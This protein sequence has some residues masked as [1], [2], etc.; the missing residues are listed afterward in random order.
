M[1]WDEHAC[2]IV[3]VGL[4]RIA[5]LPN[6]ASEQ[7]VELARAEFARLVAG[8]RIT[9]PDTTSVTDVSE[10]L[11]QASPAALER[12]VARLR[13]VETLLSGQTPTSGYSARTLRLYKQ[14]YLE[15]NACWGSGLVGLLD[16]NAK[17]GNRTPRLNAESAALLTHF[18]TQSYETLKQKSVLRVYG[19]YALACTEQGLPAASY[20]TF[21][22]K[23]HERPGGTQIRERQGPRAAYQAGPTNWRLSY[24]TP[25][26]GDFPWQYGHI[27]HTQL[28]LEMVCART[29]RVLGRPWLTVLLDAFSRRI[30][31]VYLTFDPPSYRSCM[32]VLVECVRRH[33][34][35][36]EQIMVDNG[37]DFRSIYFETLLAQHHVTK[38]ARPAAEPRVGCLI[39]RLFRT[40]ETEFVHTLQGN[41]QIMKLVRQ[42]TQTV[43]PKTQAVWTLESF[44]DYF[45]AWSYDVYDRMS[46]STLGQSP[47]AAYLAGLTANG[48]RP[49]RRVIYDEAFRLLM[50]PTTRSGAAKVQPGR[51]VKVNYLHYW[52]DAFR[53]PTVEGAVVPVKY[54]PFNAGIAYAYVNGAWER[55][56]SERYA[57][58]QGRTEREIAL[59]TAALRQQKRLDRQ[60]VNINAQTL[61]VF[62][63]SVAGQEAVLGQQLKDRA[64]QHVHASLPDPAAEPSSI[65]GRDTTEQQPASAAKPPVRWHDLEL[66]GDL[67]L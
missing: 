1:L 43:D 39:E 21:T 66:Y 24:D 16:D 33:E 49:Q 54:D 3:N 58:F 63:A 55:C 53:Q 52:S 28:N 13:A 11:R 19:E 36:P 14:R 5:L 2:A 20:T 32:A 37:S 9:L 64:V 44:Y 12:A 7:V 47:R 45:C 67:I 56:L 40:S 50:L 46:H 25:R 35:L 8:E 34:R 59:A 10:R 62:L 15:A 65:S 60:Q 17:K 38:L 30:L 57:T 22:H 42:V 61:A 4:E 27:D 6:G 18:I 41:T 26:H 23:V 51:G 29:A 31:A 48:S